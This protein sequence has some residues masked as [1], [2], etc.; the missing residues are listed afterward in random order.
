MAKK[1]MM[2]M[3]MMVIMA[4]VFSFSFILFPSGTGAQMKAELIKGMNYNTNASLADNLKTMVGKKVTIT[5]DSGSTFTGI[6]K[7][8][9]THMIHLEK[10]DGKEYYD[11]L[12]SIETIAAIDARFREPK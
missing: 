6:V 1:E 5:L 7:T 10:L 4:A 2:K 9:G 3:L 11:A 8:V 12:I